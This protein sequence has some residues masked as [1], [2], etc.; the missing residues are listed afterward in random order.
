MP[1]DTA[2]PC[3]AKQLPA[4]AVGAAVEIVDKLGHPLCPCV[5]VGRSFGL[6]FLFAGDHRRYPVSRRQ[7]GNRR[8]FVP[9]RERSTVPAKGTTAVKARELRASWIA[10]C[11]ILSASRSA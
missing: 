10:C 2:A 5:R 3:V 7:S 9:R 4:V 11:R 1:H 6:Y 8:E